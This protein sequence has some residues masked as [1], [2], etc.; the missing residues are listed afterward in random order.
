MWGSALDH[1]EE[2]QVVLADSS[3]V[4]ASSTSHPDLFFAIKGAGASFAIV[5]EFV[6]RT[7]PEPGE[8]V[9]YTFNFD[10]GS[11][12]AKATA[13]KQW[14]ALISDPAL[15]RKFA[16]QFILTAQFGALIEGTF[17]GTKAEFDSLSIAARLP[18][19]DTS[20]IEMKNWLGVVGHYA[21]NLVL[22]VGGGVQSHFTAKSLAYTK[23]DMLPDAAVDELFAYID[24]ADKGGALWF[25]I[26]DLEG[27]ATN[28][29]A[30]DATSYGHRDVLFYHQAYAINLLGPVNDQTRQFLTGVNQLVSDA[31]P[32]HE[33]AGAY[34]GYVDPS[35]GTDSA[36]LYWGG[37]VE[38]LRKIK[39][40]VDPGDVF[41][42]PQSIRPAAVQPEKP[43][44][45]ALPVM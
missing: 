42:N 43:T 20:T 22:Q 16:S 11:T 12:A 32:G 10:V 1:V 2:V 27:G 18:S 15:S 39:A 34:A 9:Q 29:I 19:H 44:L 14:Q 45:P 24:A 6:V 33:G 25:V 35:L 28:D 21:E 23:D 5:T 8:S 17:F 13:F 30:P 31:L 7:E 4:R 38:R 40:T 36:S 26:W 41:S 37:N 3:I